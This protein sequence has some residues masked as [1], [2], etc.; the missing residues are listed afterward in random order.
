MTHADEDADEDADVDEDAEDEAEDVEAGD[1]EDEDL[2]DKDTVDVDTTLIM[3]VTDPITVI[4][5][6]KKWMVLINRFL[7]KAAF[8][9]CHLSIFF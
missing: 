6:E 8:L 9:Y 3:V 5:I 4:V 2:V 1:A 7:K